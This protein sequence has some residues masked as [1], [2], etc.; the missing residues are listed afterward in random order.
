MRR[1]RMKPPPYRSTLIVILA[2]GLVGA[3]ARPGAFLDKQRLL[4]AQTFWDN[5]DWDWYQANIPFFECPDPD[6]SEPC[7]RRDAVGDLA[8]AVSPF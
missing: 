8:L 3:D 1:M 5:R 2:L 6:E 4:D 7:Q